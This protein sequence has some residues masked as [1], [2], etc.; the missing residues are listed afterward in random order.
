MDTKR[1]RTIANGKQMDLDETLIGRAREGAVLKLTIALFELDPDNPD[2]IKEM[3]SLLR[4]D[5]GALIQHLANRGSIG[6]EGWERLAE[7]FD[8]RPYD[9]W[10]AAKK[11]EYRRK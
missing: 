1:P 6:I 11:R 5:K 10:C 3:A 2:G 9:I 4:C 7:R 8:L